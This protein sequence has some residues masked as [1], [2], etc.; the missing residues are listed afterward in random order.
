[1]KK[2]TALS[3]VTVLALAML[4]PVARTVNAASVNHP[5]WSQ[6]PA[7]LPPPGGPGH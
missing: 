1:M 2:V 6:G 3:F 5:A 4:L 7:P